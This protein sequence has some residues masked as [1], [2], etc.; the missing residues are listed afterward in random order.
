MIAVA[1]DLSAKGYN[2]LPRFQG[3]SP[4]ISWKAYQAQ[5]MP[6]STLLGYLKRPNC[7]GLGVLP[8]TTSGIVVLD[9]DDPGMVSTFNQ[10]LTFH[11]K[12]HC[13]WYKTSRGFHLWFRLWGGPPI[14]GSMHIAG[15]DLLTQGAFVVCP[16]RPSARSFPGPV[17]RPGELPPLP[18]GVLNVFTDPP[19]TI[20]ET[21]NIR[22]A[23]AHYWK[24]DREPIP[25]G[26]RNNTL[27]R[28]GCWYLSR[29][30]DTYRITQTLI[31]RAT[32]IDGL[33]V[34]EATQ[35]LDNALAHVRDDSQNE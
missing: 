9:I 33:S 20:R 4:G 8:G 10:V 16:P 26:A 18:Q 1:S 6:W 27:F 31:D 34:E 22:D 32:T 13:V 3:K 2:V 24:P 30:Q 21:V 14:D 12:K 17:P 28:V 25:E 11:Q 7:M 5:M 19:G 23:A 35:C 15:S 29:T